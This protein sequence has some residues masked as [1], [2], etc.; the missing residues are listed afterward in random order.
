MSTYKIE[1]GTAQHVGSRPQQN[2]RV[3]L[4]TA[5]KAPGYVL[6]VLADGL[7]G[8]AAGAEQVLHT[9]K[10]LFDEYRASES[11]SLARVEE[12]LREIA[13]DVHQ[14]L[15]MDP[16]T[17]ASEPQASMVLMLLTP[18]RQAAWAV[19][20]DSRLYRFDHKECVGRSSDAEYVAHL[21]EQE[22]LPED[23]ARK[24][25]QAKLLNNVLGNKQKE[26]FVAFGLQENLKAGDA[27]LLCSDGLWS[28]FAD[29]ELA[30]VIAKKSPREAAEL[31]I[32]KARERAQGKGDN[33]SMAILKLVAPPKEE[34]NYTVQ[35]LRKAI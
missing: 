21:M 17:G 28:Y 9:A 8:G 1:A 27:F 15:V 4:F 33:C 32:N 25:R 18:Q 14:I 19:V 13:H 11:V 31:L 3:A 16:R 23:A 22:K 5:P 20:G 26:P 10:Q 7:S 35:K 24:H 30:T 29:V 12:F 2:D 34:V 6:A